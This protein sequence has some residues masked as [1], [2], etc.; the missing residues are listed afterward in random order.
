[1]NFF[2]AQERARK[3]SRLLVWWFILSVMGVIVVMYFLATAFTLFSASNPGGMYVV[4]DVGSLD[5]WDPSLLLWTSVTVGG[6]IMIGS[7]IKLAQLSAGGK[8]VAQSLGGRAVEPTTTDLPERRL[9]NVVEEMAIA[10]GVPVPEVW[11]MDEEQ[12]INAFAAG[13]D[14]TNAVVGVTRGTLE[15]LTRSE[16]QGVVAHEFSHILNGD[17]KL[18]MRLM[19]WIFGLVMLSMLGRI[20]LESFRFMRGSRDSKGGGVVMAV[21][22][23]GLAVWLVGSIGVLFARMLQAAISRQREYLADASAVQFTRDP[24]GIAGALK[25]IGGFAEHGKISSPKAMEARHM[26]FA[27]SG[28]SLMMS[29]H[30]PLE[31]RILA[32]DPGWKGQMSEGKADPVTREEFTGA[33]G[34]S[35]SLEQL[36]SGDRLSLGESGRMNTQVGAMIREELREGK[37]TSFS[38][39]EAKALLLGLLVAA[40]AD[41]R[42]KGKGIL[43]EH[44]S[45]DDFVGQVIVWSVN[46]ESYNS[47]KKLALVDLSL[48]W[49]RKM[50][51]AEAKDFVKSSQALIEADG[52][53]NLFE[54]MLQKVIERNVSMGLGLKPVPA[55][56]YRKLGD[57]EKEIGQVLG[58]FSNLAGGEA[59][60]GKAAA[61]YLEHTGNDLPRIGADLGDVSRALL[62]MDA[63]TPLVKQQILRLCS[64][65]VLDDEVVEDRELELLRATA[66]AIGAP[67]PPLVRRR[68]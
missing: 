51:Q 35:G 2:E 6:V 9:L 11:I 44:G 15:R 58:A 56:K 55:M 64:L 10:A 52:E 67:V 37:V 16:L 40:D 39:Q 5:W 30:P 54:F 61:E 59:A 12:G 27:G 7:W 1:M 20:M 47:S 43:R 23:A 34:F 17:M 38:K 53:V 24:G 48:S 13:T 33:M 26:F 32:I 60:M 65:V 28:L 63:A 66:E 22:V 21:I 50:S 62:E 4:E 29:T 8:V 19:G 25:K 18:N 46:L 36:D 49:L 68:V 57:L 31:K 3:S 14:P 45:D 41:G 42:E